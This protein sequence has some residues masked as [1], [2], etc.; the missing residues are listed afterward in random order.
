MANK[1]DERRRIAANIRRV[2]NIA[3]IAGIVVLVA[4]AVTGVLRLIEFYSQEVGLSAPNAAETYARALYEGNLDTVYNMTDAASLTDL[5]GR[6][7]ERVA[8]MAEARELR[9]SDPRTVERI[10]VDKLFDADGVH[11][12]LVSVIFSADGGPVSR[13]LLLQ[14]RN[15]EGSWRV[16]WPFGLAP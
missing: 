1:M 16:A 3:R 7:V 5:Y 14:L 12:Y 9:G 6:P 11:Y 15:D 10:K 2:V 4:I 13:E 8:F